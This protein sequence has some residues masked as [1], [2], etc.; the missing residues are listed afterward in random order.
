ML[1]NS[2]ICHEAWG[3]HAQSTLSMKL[4][5][6]AYSTTTVAMGSWALLEPAVVRGIDRSPAR[7][8]VS[9]RGAATAPVPNVRHVSLQS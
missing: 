8:V 1:E 4:P 5:L 7:R 2:E 6:D 9:R 3:D